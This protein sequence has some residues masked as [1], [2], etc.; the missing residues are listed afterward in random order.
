MVEENINIFLFC[1]NIKELKFISHAAEGI[2]VSITLPRDKEDL[3]ASG[4]A[5]HQI[6]SLLDDG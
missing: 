1:C 6:G 2:W 5:N 4:K 3:N